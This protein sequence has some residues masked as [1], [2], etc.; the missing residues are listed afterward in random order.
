[1]DYYSDNSSDSV[2]EL[3]GRDIRELIFQSFGRFDL[4]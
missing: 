3:R 2:L 1:M 4:G